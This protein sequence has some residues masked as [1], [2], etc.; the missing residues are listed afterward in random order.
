MTHLLDWHINDFLR[1]CLIWR[2]ALVTST[3]MVMQNLGHP[4]LDLGTWR[5]RGT[6]SSSASSEA[7]LRSEMCS[8][9]AS[10]DLSRDTSGS[11]SI[12]SSSMGISLDSTLKS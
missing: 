9:E 12:R 11:V 8:S 6:M 10:R 5:Y 7:T 2:P 4:V 1:P 3:L